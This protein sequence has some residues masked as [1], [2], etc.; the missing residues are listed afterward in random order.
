MK[1]RHLLIAIALAALPALGVQSIGAQTPADARTKLAARLDTG[2]VAVILPIIDAA[3]AQGLPI[4]PLVQKALEGASKRAPA[5]RIA[6]A[7][8][9]LSTQLGTARTALGSNASATELVAGAS[10]L[11]A[12]VRS[13]VLATLHDE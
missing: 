12:G 6:F 9:R 4:D 1:I 2:A 5:D 13:E 10:A 3:Q 7:L 11:Q 8:R